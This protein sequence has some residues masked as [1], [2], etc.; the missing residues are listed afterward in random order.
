MQVLRTYAPHSDCS[1]FTLKPA[2]YSFLG[3]KVPFYLNPVL[4]VV[5][6]EW[7]M[8]I[9]LLNYHKILVVVVWGS[10]VGGGCLSGPEHIVCLPQ[11]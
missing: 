2:S 6:I 10:L 5:D 1:E 8:H 9:Q 4:I 3:I 11:A 7:L